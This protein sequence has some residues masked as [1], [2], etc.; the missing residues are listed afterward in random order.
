[1]AINGLNGVNLETLTGV[2][3]EEGQSTKT[4]LNHILSFAENYSNDDEPS[5]AKIKTIF[6]KSMIMSK[7]NISE[8]N[9][10]RKNIEGYLGLLIKVAQ[11]LNGVQKNNVK[12]NGTQEQN[13][14]YRVTISGMVEEMKTH[15]N[16][17]GCGLSIVQDSKTGLYKL[18]IENKLYDIPE[19]NVELKTIH[20]DF[21]DEFVPEIVD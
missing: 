14:T 16:T 19:R 9:L 12:P 1:M 2:Q 15:A 13:E 10:S 6:F 5:E 11:K 8:S 4:Q 17:I 7:L 20:T 3:K 21:G 18:C